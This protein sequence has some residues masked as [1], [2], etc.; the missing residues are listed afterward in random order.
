MRFKDL[1]NYNCGRI[2]QLSEDTAKEIRSRVRKPRR[3][4]SRPVKGEVIDV[5]KSWTV[6]F[7]TNAITSKKVDHYLQTVR[8]I[9]PPTGK[10]TLDKVREAFKSDIQILCSCP[11]HRYYGLSYYAKQGNYGP[12]RIGQAFDIYPKI[13]NPKPNP[14]KGTCKHGMVILQILVANAPKIMKMY[15][16]KYSI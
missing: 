12:Q 11:D 5:N 9:N 8:P 2:E 7:K 14:E 13:K 1:Y 16:D 15:K 10:I 4:R 3:E 6:T